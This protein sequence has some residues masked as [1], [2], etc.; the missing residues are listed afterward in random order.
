MFLS[1]TVVL[2]L[3]IA[4]LA[5]DTG[6]HRVLRRDLQALVDV[7]ALD[8]A[9]ELGTKTQAQLEPELDQSDPTSALS[10]SLARNAG[11]VLG[12]ELVVTGDFGAWNGATWDTTADP[13]SAVRVQAWGEVGFAFAAGAGEAS[14]TAYAGVQSGACY[15]VGSYAAQ[16][17]T[18]DSAL[19]N[20]FFQRLA[21]SVGLFNNSGAVGALNYKG[22]AQASVELDGVAGRLGIGSVSEL[23]H[24][25]VDM[26]QLFGAVHAQV[27]ADNGQSSVVDALNVLALQAHPGV[28]V[29]M[30]RVLGISSSGMGVGLTANVLDL[31]G[32][33]LALL[34]GTNLVDMNVA[35]GVPGLANANVKTRLIQGPRH[36]CGRVGD[37]FSNATASSTEQLYFDVNASLSP[38]T[39]PIAIPAGGIFTLPV[40]TTVTGPNN[41]H[42]VGSL[43]PTETEL[44]GLTCGAEGEGGV[45]MDVRNGLATVTVGPWYVSNLVFTTKL[46]GLDVRITFNA[47][48]TATVT[49]SHGE[50]VDFSISVP[51]DDFDTFYPTT[52]SGVGLT[53]NT[54]GSQPGYIAVTLLNWLPVVLTAPQLSTLTSSLLQAIVRPMFDTSVAGSLVNVLINPLLA[55]A[56]VDIG[57][58]DVALDSAP[59]PQCANPR[60]SG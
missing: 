5:V 6:M 55:I 47:N 56:G 7:V 51:P 36:Y 22:L 52:T 38:V 15:Q 59:A 35:S 48:I 19:W 2:L 16:V 18:S 60:L 50:V 42:V 41:L 8:L 13:P 32:G 11:D 31:V 43:A 21:S 49:I 40:S 46:L 58:A 20:I 25:T 10:R 34:N 54:T 53:V 23:A 45:T 30:S 14:R 3:G 29:A 39:Y 4:S 24:A 17:N 57:G 1:V 27:L 26:K 9:R 33:S 37:V 12:E 44:T 28:Q